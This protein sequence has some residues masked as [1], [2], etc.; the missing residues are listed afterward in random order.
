MGHR[1]LATQESALV[2]RERVSDV[3]FAPPD[4]YK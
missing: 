1:I 2:D 3:D 4:S